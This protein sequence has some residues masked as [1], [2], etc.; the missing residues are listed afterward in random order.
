MM[1]SYN[2]DSDADSFIYDRCEIPKRCYRMKARAIC[3]SF[4]YYERGLPETDDL[5]EGRPIDDDNDEVPPPLKVFPIAKQRSN[6]TEL[7]TVLLNPLNP[8]PA[9]RPQS[10]QSKW[11]TIAP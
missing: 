4:C 3:M 7:M 11:F 1:E 2:D 5:Q 10:D 9:D 8:D 6:T